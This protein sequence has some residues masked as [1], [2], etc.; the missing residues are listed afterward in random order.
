MY[1][2]TMISLPEETE[3]RQRLNVTFDRLMSEIKAG[4]LIQN[5]SD[6]DA[7]ARVLYDVVESRKLNEV[8]EKTFKKELRR[9]IPE[10]KLILDLAT[11]LITVDKRTRRDLD[12]ERMM[13]DMG[14][15]FMERYQTKCEYEI[16]TV[17][18][19]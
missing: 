13:E 1:E 16:L 3:L 11:T 8:H 18:V 10:G 14:M 7:L 6:L 2:K 15:E 4:R 9:F 5:E 19:K 12:R 17:R